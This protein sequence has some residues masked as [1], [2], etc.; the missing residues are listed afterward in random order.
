MY[1]RLGR[2]MF[3]ALSKLLQSISRECCVPPSNACTILHVLFIEVC[4]CLLLHCI[5]TMLLYV[6]VST[7]S[8][9]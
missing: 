9:I 6:V 4:V 2:G 1:V 8:R 5:I 3:K 7:S